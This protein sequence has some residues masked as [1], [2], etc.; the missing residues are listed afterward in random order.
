MAIL[1]FTASAHPHTRSCAKSRRAHSILRTN[2][3]CALRGCKGESWGGLKLRRAGLGCMLAWGGTARVLYDE[4]VGRGCLYS[5]LVTLYAPEKWW[6]LP[7]V[8]ETLVHMV[9]CWWARSRHSLT[10]MGCTK[11]GGNGQNVPTSG[12]NKKWDPIN[13][14]KK[15]DYWRQNQIKLIIHFNI[16]VA[17]NC[18]NYCCW[19]W[20]LIEA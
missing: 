1:L 17:R 19:Y 20:L 16:I 11:G 15:I 10:A 18:W 12:N 8:V 13:G 2:G 6:G 9:V 7:P 4:A 5:L 3:A 14:P